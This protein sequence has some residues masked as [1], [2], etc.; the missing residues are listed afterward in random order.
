MDWI[1][2]KKIEQEQRGVKILDVSASGDVVT[3]SQFNLDDTQLQLLDRQESGVSESMEGVGRQEQSTLAM[4]P[5]PSSWFEQSE[6]MIGK[7]LMNEAL[8]GISSSRSD[9]RI[10]D[11]ALEYELCRNLKRP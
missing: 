1:Q 2:E 11:E 8:E 7:E 10:I 5:I 9:L 3:Q 4:S 6:K